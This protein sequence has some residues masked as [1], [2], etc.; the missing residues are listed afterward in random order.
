MNTSD[1]RTRS[2]GRNGTHDDDNGTIKSNDQE[3]TSGITGSNIGLNE[4][5]KAKQ[6]LLRLGCFTNL[7]AFLSVSIELSDSVVAGLSMTCDGNRSALA[8]PCWLLYSV[9][10]H[11]ELR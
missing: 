3:T 11:S 1:N 4:E 5:E 8:E 6:A 7:D 2:T 10:E 9:I